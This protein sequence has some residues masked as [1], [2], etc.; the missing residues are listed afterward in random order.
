M[1]NPFDL[2]KMPSDSKTPVRI[3]MDQW[4]ARDVMG[5]LQRLVKGDIR[6]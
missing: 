1:Q 5:G 6:R 2:S 4:D 3:E